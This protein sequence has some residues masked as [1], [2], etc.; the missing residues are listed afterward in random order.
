MS[1]EFYKTLHF[2]GLILTFSSLFS[3]LFLVFYPN[4]EN[5]KIL[6]KLGLAHGIGLLIIFISGF[7]LAARL[8]YFS[9]LPNWVYV[10]MILWAIT[11]GLIAVI[12]R[13]KLQALPLYIILLLI[14]LVASIIAINKPF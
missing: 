10:K 14:P 8:G 1:Y 13:K 3:F 11:G 9:Q 5:T 2:F 7:G 12:K 4:N 6:K